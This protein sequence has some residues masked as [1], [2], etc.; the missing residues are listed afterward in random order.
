MSVKKHSDDES[1]VIMG[2]DPG[3]SI[4]GYGVIKS[5]NGEVW[6]VEAGVIKTN[7]ADELGSRIHEIYGGIGSVIQEFKPDLIAVEELYAHYKHPK[8]AIIMGHAR[9]MIFLQSA[10]SGVPIQSYA[11][12]KVK[13]ALTG[14]GHA[15]KEQMQAMIKARLGLK[16]VPRPADAAD[17]LAV[18]LCH[19]HNAHQLSGA[20]YA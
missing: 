1:I 4:T 11:A 15:T 6:M 19:L 13:S 5:E 10:Q 14:N 3:L 2:V 8:T 16:D 9:A 17:A 20:V 7:P 12:T 18:A